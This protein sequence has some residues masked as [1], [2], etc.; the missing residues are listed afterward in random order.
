MRSLLEA[1]ADV[2]LTGEAGWTPL[3]VAIFSEYRELT[4]LLIENGADQK[5]TATDGVTPMALALQAGDD[6]LIALL[7]ERSSDKPLLRGA[8]SDEQMETILPCRIPNQE[9]LLYVLGRSCIAAG[10]KILRRIPRKSGPR[11]RPERRRSRL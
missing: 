10:G 6:D 8:L 7:A 4:A 1:G 5:F 9:P 3:M 2:D 11:N